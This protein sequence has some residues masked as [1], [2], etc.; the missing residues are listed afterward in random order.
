MVA[1]HPAE[2]QA[3]SGFA[4]EEVT[5]TMRQKTGEETSF[6]SSHASPPHSHPRHALFSSRWRYEICFFKS[7]SLTASNPSHLPVISPAADLKDGGPHPTM[8]GR[9]WKSHQSHLALPHRPPGYGFPRLQPQTR[10]QPQPQRG[11]YLYSSPGCVTLNHS[12]GLI[13]RHPHTS[14]HSHFIS[15][16]MQIFPAALTSLPLVRTNHLWA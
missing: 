8:T 9:R 11:H 4:G 13:A 5:A 10:P 6:V 1:Q 2:L 7:C 3:Q 14:T 12:A 15:V 16:A